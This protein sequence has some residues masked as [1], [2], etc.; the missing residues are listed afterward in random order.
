[1]AKSVNTSLIGAGETVTYTLN[2]V[3]VGGTTATGVTV[4]DDFPNPTWFSY[5]TDSC[6]PL[7]GSCAVAAGVLTWTVGNLAP[8]QSATLRF[9]MRS[10]AT[11]IPA[12]V[13]QLDNAAVASDASYCTGGSPPAGG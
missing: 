2:V 12:G 13:T 1:M 6:E 4:T 5:V 8:G 7:T 10:A 11:G 9:Q 3:N